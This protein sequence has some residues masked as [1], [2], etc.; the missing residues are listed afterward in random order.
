MKTET[1]PTTEDYVSEALLAEV[2]LVKSEEIIPDGIGVQRVPSFELAADTVLIEAH[3]FESL[4]LT[5]DGEKDGVRLRF[6]LAKYPVV[7]WAL[8]SP[9]AEY[10][11]EVVT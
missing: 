5:V 6:T 2:E 8:R 3:D 4:P 9:G 10:G 7:R 1:E 11:V